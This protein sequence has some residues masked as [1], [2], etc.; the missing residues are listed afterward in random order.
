MRVSRRVLRGWVCLSMGA[1]LAAIISLVPAA[2]AQ[3]AGAPAP[4]PTVRAGATSSLVVLADDEL[5]AVLV[6]DDKTRRVVLYRRNGGKLE[7]A[8]TRSL[9]DDLAKLVVPPAPVYSP[10][11]FPTEDVPGVDPQDWK[12]PKGWVRVRSSYS[13]SSNGESWEARYASALPVA[14]VSTAMR[15][16]LGDWQLEYLEVN[17][18]SFRLQARRDGATLS[19][20]SNDARSSQWTEITVS[21]SRPK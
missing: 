10:P 7:V 19:V 13:V 15:E 17:E 16:R 8:T 11:E 9:D 2:W 3:E 18:N 5:D 14:E 12:R 20:K 6:I 4:Q 1:A 21:L